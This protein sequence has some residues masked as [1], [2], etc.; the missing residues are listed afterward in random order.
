MQKWILPFRVVVPVLV[1]SVLFFSAHYAYDWVEVEN[2]Q[3][4]EIIKDQAT[5]LAEALVSFYEKEVK[6]P[7]G[8][9]ANS[10]TASNKIDIEQLINA[11]LLNT[12]YKAN[13][14]IYV[15][16]GGGEKDKVWVCFVP[17]SKHKRVDRI[18]LKSLSPGEPLPENGEPSW[19]EPS[20]DWQNSFCYSCVAR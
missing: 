10:W 19:C 2:G 14:E 11:E 8:S 18:K 5:T 3:R 17:Q 1:L 9:L 13:P 7:W 15:G 6:F 16:R 12:S 20:P 4:D